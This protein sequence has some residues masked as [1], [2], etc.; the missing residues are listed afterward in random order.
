MLRTLLQ[1]RL[2]AFEREWHY[3]MSYARFLLKTSPRALLKFL[4]VMGFARHHENAPMA[5]QAAAGLYAAMAED[6]GPCIQ[7]GAHMAERAGVRPQV[8]RAILAGDESAMGDDARLGFRYARLTLHHDPEAASLREEIVARWG[9]RALVS[10]AFAVTA[11]R[12]FPTL[13]YALGYGQSCSR[14]IRVAGDDAPVA[15]QAAR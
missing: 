3:D 14:A 5:A 12:I 8:V 11:A 6:C 13:K 4:P 15:L 1:W 10:L 2:N 7:L 9:E